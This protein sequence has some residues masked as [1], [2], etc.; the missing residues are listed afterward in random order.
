MLIA[1]S[2]LRVNYL[3]F[4]TFLT[5]Y[6]LIT[7]HFLNP[8][9]FK[10]LIGERLVDTLIGSIIAALAARFIFPVWQ[11]YNIQPAMKKLLI[12]NTTYF[13]AAWNSQKDPITHRKQYNAARNEAIVTLTNLT[14]NFQQMLAEPGQSKLY[15]HVHQF[16]ITS[17]TLTG[18]ISAFSPRDILVVKDSPRWVD[19]ILDTFNEAVATLEADNKVTLSVNE[20]SIQDKDGL[21]ALSIIHSLAD[22]L[23]NIS[24]RVTTKDA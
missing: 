11:H 18:R 9:E 22:E 12:A 8:V 3:A 14:D 7:F 19:K 20:N 5:T 15:T 10:S 17:H 4:V 24:I 13:L 21:H 1:Y 6:V 16:V 23:R 2:L